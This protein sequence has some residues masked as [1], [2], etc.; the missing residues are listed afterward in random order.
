MAK[1]LLKAIANPLSSDRER[2]S[3]KVGFACNY[4]TQRKGHV[5]AVV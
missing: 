4:C 3:G 2:K 1:Q 5:I